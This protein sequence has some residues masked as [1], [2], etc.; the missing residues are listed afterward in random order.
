MLI[1]T[2]CHLDDARL[3]GDEEAILE[4]AREMGV[5]TLVTI[6]T[7]ETTSAAAAKIAARYPGKIYHTIGAHPSDV[8]R[9][10]DEI[11]KTIEQ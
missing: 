1:D 9:F 5:E 4:K 11:L 3:I 8:D 7:D 2:H 10:D 6:G